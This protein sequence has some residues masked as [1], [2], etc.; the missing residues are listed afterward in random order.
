MDELGVPP[1]AIHP[2]VPVDE[3]TLS[4]VK[5][6]G[7]PR[8]T[9]SDPEINSGLAGVP[10]TLIMSL[11]SLQRKE[12][13]ASKIYIPGPELKCIFQLP[14]PESFLTMMESCVSTQCV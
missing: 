1:T 6:E 4:A 5:S 12:S 9:E 3:V 11:G 8:H 13:L 10:A 14:T 2:G 7:L